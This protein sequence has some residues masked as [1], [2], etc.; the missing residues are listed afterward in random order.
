MGAI[1]AEAPSVR[2]GSA[3]KEFPGSLAGDHEAT[4]L[5]IAVTAVRSGG[6]SFKTSDGYSLHHL[7]CEIAQEY[8]IE[9]PS[10]HAG[11]WKKSLVSC[12]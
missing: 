2:T 7:H 1:S 4:H 9:R 12:L 10:E 11:L 6:C 3:A 8:G 5:A